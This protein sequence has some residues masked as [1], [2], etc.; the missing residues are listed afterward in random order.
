MYFRTAVLLCDPYLPVKDLPVMH[1]LESEAH[2]DKPVQ[3]DVLRQLR[4]T[5][6]LE[7]AVDIACACR[8]GVW[9]QA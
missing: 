3:D 5:A 7:E 1:V 9:G 6:L 2:L 4:P 8:A